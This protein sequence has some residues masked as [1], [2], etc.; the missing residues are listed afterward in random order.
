MAV[1]VDGGASN[2]DRAKQVEPNNDKFKINGTEG[3]GSE[4]PV[5]NTRDLSAR[6]EQAQ[7]QANLI[8]NQLQRFDGTAKGAAKKNNE[9]GPANNAKGK[10]GSLTANN[11]ANPGL[12]R[13]QGN[14][15]AL[16]L[17]ERANPNL[18]NSRANTGSLKNN[19]IANGGSRPTLGNGN[20]SSLTGKDFANPGLGLGR[21]N[22]LQP[23]PS[24]RSNSDAGLNLSDIFG[25]ADGGST[26]QLPKIE[27]KLELPVLARGRR[28]KTDDL[29]ILD[30]I[31][32]SN[33]DF[34]SS[35]SNSLELDNE[36]PE[37]EP[38]ESPEDFFDTAE[39]LIG[40]KLPLSNEERTDD[41]TV[42]TDL[43]LLELPFDP[44][45]SELEKQAE[46][47][48]AS[49]TEVD[50]PLP[51]RKP[52]IK[53]NS[54]SETTSEVPED[55]ITTAKPEVDPE[56]VINEVIEQE[57]SV[58]LFE[59]V[60]VPE[61][62]IGKEGVS[63]EQL[64][65][66]VANLFE[67][68]QTTQVSTQVASPND[69]SGE[70]LIQ[71]GETVIPGDVLEQVSFSLPATITGKEN[72]SSLIGKRIFP[73][74]L[75]RETEAKPINLRSEATVIRGKEIPARDENSAIEATRA[76]IRNPGMPLNLNNATREAMEEFN[77]AIDAERDREI[78]EPYIFWTE[79]IYAAAEK[80]QIEPAIIVG[81]MDRESGGENI[82]DAD[83]HKYGLMG[84]DDRQY[85]EW[86]EE[87]KQG[88]DP[89]TNIDFGTS[90]LRKQLNYFRGH[91]AAALAAYDAGRGA[92][93]WAISS[94]LD[95]DVVTTN[96]NYSA[97][98]LARAD[99]FRNFFS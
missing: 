59:N 15:G 38:R 54:T 36:R 25:D 21:G 7:E 46:Q 58:S 49:L 98:V 68:E 50:L 18:G 30:N 99:F 93:S 11:Q 35:L 41:G 75:L 16:K 4:S 76:N 79:F 10:S 12:A 71:A 96:K 24:S 8:K 60:L 62:G 87:N 84:I 66:Q 40:K 14:S 57:L 47:S 69:K 48:L 9:T 64:A 13:G 6:P 5:G 22:D 88:L 95:V 55:P 89:A 28:D 65:E 78:P 26:V 34:G 44:F 2:V 90:L 97:D 32:L 86:L 3:S 91:V 72:N 56:V 83:R 37:N 85:S 23:G 80:Y 63:L 19:Q 81:L 70:E 94:Q 51:I 74:S 20:N 92:V 45:S 77:S 42:L 27:I 43:L 1:R 73:E 33:D 17:P 29:S 82:I 53:P 52:L 61:D 31:L 67:N 39:R